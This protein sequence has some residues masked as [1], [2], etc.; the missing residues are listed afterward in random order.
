MEVGSVSS[1]V[2]AAA[3]TPVRPAGQ[4]QQ[5]LQAQQARQTKLTQNAQTAQTT[6][7][8]TGNESADRARLAAEKNRPSVNTSGQTVGQ[9]IN[10]TA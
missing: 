2:N 10:V 4:D 3:N 5:T 6:Q 9:R 8:V 1:S 7:A